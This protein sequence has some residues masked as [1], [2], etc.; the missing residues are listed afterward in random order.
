CP[1]GSDLS[2]IAEFEIGLVVANVSRHAAEIDL[3]LIEA[4]HAVGEARVDDASAEAIVRPLRDQ[5]GEHDPGVDLEIDQIAVRRTDRRAAEHRY[6]A[7]RRAAAQTVELLVDDAVDTEV[8]AMLRR[9]ST[10]RRIG[11]QAAI[12]S[13]ALIGELAEMA[14][15]SELQRPGKSAVVLALIGPELRLADDQGRIAQSEIE[16]VA[17]AGIGIASAGP[18]GIAVENGQQERRILAVVEFRPRAE[19]GQ[20]ISRTAPRQSDRHAGWTVGLHENGAEVAEEEF[21]V[22]SELAHSETGSAAEKFPLEPQL[23]RRVA[24]VASIAAIV[25]MPPT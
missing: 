12:I 8:A 17:V 10:P 14:P 1:A 22:G 21:A 24:G 9:N 23:D 2:D 20:W 7:V 19:R 3:V 16:T 13:V 4:T 25:F 18:G 6:A 5:A 11:K 15:P